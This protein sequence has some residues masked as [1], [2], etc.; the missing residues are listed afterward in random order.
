M[1]AS[2][3]A[4]Q[5]AQIAAELEVIDFI[6]TYGMEEVRKK[7][8][9]KTVTSY[10]LRNLDFDMKKSISDP[11]NPGRVVEHTMNV[12]APLLSIIQPPSLVIEEANIDVS[13]DVM[14]EKENKSKSKL[15]ASKSTSADFFAIA[16]PNIRLRG[17]VGRGTANSSFRNKGKVQVSLKLRSAKDQMGTSRFLRII[18]E[19]LK[20]KIDETDLKKNG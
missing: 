14:L 16:K 4:V 13:L 2:I 17:Q 9:K 1:G 11:S 19:G 12:S 18:S 8:G 15:N 5:E 3:Q 10:Q 6:L 7:K 20:T